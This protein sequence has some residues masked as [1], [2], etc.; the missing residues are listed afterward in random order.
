MKKI[1]VFTLILV[2]FSSIVSAQDSAI[3]ADQPIQAGT[4]LFFD[5]EVD[6]VLY[7]N[8]GEET[9]LGTFEEISLEG[10]GTTKA[11]V[12][13]QNDFG[14]WVMIQE[15]EFTAPAGGSVDLTVIINA[16][17]I[18]G[19]GQQILINPGE[20]R[21]TYIFTINKIIKLIVTNP[22]IVTEPIITTDG[23]PGIVPTISDKQQQ[24]I[25]TILGTLSLTLATQED[26]AGK[27][28]LFLAA[29][30]SL[31]DILGVTVFNAISFN[32]PINGIVDTF[33]IGNPDADADGFPDGV[34]VEGVPTPEQ[35][36]PPPVPEP[37]VYGDCKC[38]IVVSAYLDGCNRWEDQL[39]DEVM[40]FGEGDWTSVGHPAIHAHGYLTQKNINANT[41]QQ[42]VAWVQ[43]DEDGLGDWMGW[44]WEETT[45]LGPCD[46]ESPECRDSCDQQVTY[47]EDQHKKHPKFLEAQN[48]LDSNKYR[49]RDPPSGATPH[50]PHIYTSGTC[51]VAGASADTPAPAAG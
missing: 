48:F 38:R 29:G 17:E 34:E 47:E 22:P 18:T 39:A 27:F 25:Q 30:G 26:V 3:D 31:A 20:T 50:G 13:A 41:V 21:T 51:E 15:N 10:P 36:P 32:D 45:D 1:I 23:R 9:I 33:T 2:L 16:I 14:V 11:E 6:T 4:Y 12:F 5:D 35:P 37:K 19:D 28:A 46:P 49:C 7:A 44:R 8:I 43:D 24:D 42:M 40:P